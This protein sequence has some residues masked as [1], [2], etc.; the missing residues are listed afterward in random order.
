M[1]DFNPAGDRLHLEQLELDVRIGV[2]DE[3]RAKP[4]RL[5]INLTVW[6]D[7]HFGQLNDDIN[8]TINYVELCRA[9]REFVQS[10]DWK[11]IET[12]ASDLSSQLLEKFA[13]GAV[14]IEVRKFVLPNTAFVSATVRRSR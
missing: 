3:E 9:T 7:V 6:P 4:Q 2:T 13:I 8:R 10:R 12:V 1:T 14:E 5:V 11:L